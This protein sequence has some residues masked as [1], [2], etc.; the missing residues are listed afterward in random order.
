MK[1]AGLFAGIGGLEVGM[2][3]AGH[4]M[5][6]A[7]EILPAARAVL[8]RRLPGVELVGDVR[9]LAKLPSDVDLVVAG[10]P[11]QDLSQAGLAR[12]L[13]GDRSGLVEEVFRLAAEAKTPWIVLEMCR[14]CCSCGR[15]LPCA[16]SSI[17]W[18]SLVTSGLGE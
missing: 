10:F 5:L 3:R 13:D 11:C 18:K 4:E 9:E 15:A 6:L 1:I 17:D 7:S 2:A 14:S 16:A 12:G 8:E